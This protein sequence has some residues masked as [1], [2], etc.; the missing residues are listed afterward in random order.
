MNRLKNVKPVEFGLGSKEEEAIIFYNPDNIGGSSIAI[1]P[2]VNKKQRITITTID[3]FTNRNNLNLGL[4][5]LDTEG[6]ESN[7]IRG[8]KKSIEKYRPVMLISIYHTPE[9]FLK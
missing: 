3:D 6:F 2:D 1:Q 7:I 9:D 5:K 8:A 4:I